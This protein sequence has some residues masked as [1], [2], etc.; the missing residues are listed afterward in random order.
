MDEELRAMGSLEKD[1][2]KFDGNESSVPIAGQEIVSLNT[3]GQSLNTL[4][5]CLNT[6]G[7]CLNKLGESLNTLDESLK[8][9]GECA[10]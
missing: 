7:E 3:F 1:S 6:L 8:L 10:E 9:L 4:C 5:E 2:L